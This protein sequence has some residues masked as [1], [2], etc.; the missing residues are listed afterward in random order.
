ME[1]KLMNSVDESSIVSKQERSSRVF[2][3]N[4]H[5]KDNVQPDIKICYWTCSLKGIYTHFYTETLNV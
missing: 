2:T 1:T 5:T 3:E 4:L